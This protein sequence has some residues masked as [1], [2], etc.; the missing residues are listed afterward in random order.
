MKF[1]N[2]YNLPGILLRAVTKQ[3]AKYD[4]GN[5]HRS[6]TQ[7]IQPPRIDILRKKHFREM[8]KDL[9]EEWWG[10]LGSAV[11]HIL[12]MGADKGETTEERFF[13]TVD[14][15]KLSGACDLQEHHADS[16]VSFSDYKVTTSFAVMSGEEG[17]KE[18]WEYQLNLL[19]YLARKSKNLVIRD[20]TIVAIIRDWQR[21]QAEVNRDYPQAPV[22]P[23]R[24]PVWPMEKAEQYIKDRV[25]AHRIA[26]FTQKMTGDLPDCSDYERWVRGDSWIVQKEGNKRATKRVDTEAEAVAYIEKEVKKDK[27]KYR[28]VFRRGEPVRCMGNYCQVAAWCSQWQKEKAEQD[29]GNAGSEDG[30]EMG[31]AVHG[32]GTPKE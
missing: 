4:R 17:F 2:R 19:A 9:S 7:L 12:E 32:D 20:L 14:G 24:I 25:N 1:T 27:D 31:L 22:L 6:V 23:I 29:A 26:E 21:K 13:A 10:L 18:E 8:E 3:N 30:G 15:W 11:H 5:V 16:S 28:A